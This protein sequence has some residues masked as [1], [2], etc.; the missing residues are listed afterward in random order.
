MECIDFKKPK[1]CR[2]AI[3][4]LCSV[5][6][7][8]LIMGVF[9][10]KSRRDIETI[11]VSSNEQ[12]IAYY[13]T[14]NGPKICCISADGTLVFCYDISVELSEGGNCTLWFD[15][16]LLYALF[17]RSDKVACFSKN[18][19]IMSVTDSWFEN[20]PPVFPEFDRIH[21]QFVYTGEQINVTYNKQRFWDYWLLGKP[22]Y[23]EITPNDGGTI[24]ALSWTA[25]NG[26]SK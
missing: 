25:K 2:I 18:G 7:G 8:L 5:I 20:D 15:E 11:A 16:G 24:V 4:L 22:R 1:H 19:T 23:L 6:L 26:R 12:Y 14:G 3:V 17:Y 9:S 10:G 13:E 21:S